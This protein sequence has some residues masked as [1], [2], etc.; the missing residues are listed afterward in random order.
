MR[1]HLCYYF[2]RSYL[3]KIFTKLQ[4]LETFKCRIIFDDLPDDE[5]FN[6]QEFFSDIREIF[7]RIRK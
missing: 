6:E 3:L 7:G 5:D 4:A 2:R 1:E